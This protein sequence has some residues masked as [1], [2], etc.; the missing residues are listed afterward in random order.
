M[1]VSY[2]ILPAFLVLC[3]AA[4]PAIAWDA[5]EYQN[6]QG[7]W[8]LWSSGAVELG[9]KYECLSNA[10]GSDPAK[11]D[12]LLDVENNK[13]EYYEFK[14]LVEVSLNSDVE[15]QD[16]LNSALKYRRNVAALEKLI[17]PLPSVRETLCFTEIDW[18]SKHALKTLYGER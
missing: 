1:K 5:A 10:W 6:L 17:G 14:A 18:F 7:L 15:Y 11:V 12:K 16:I 4:K 13:Q 8:A 2:K 9:A 3:L